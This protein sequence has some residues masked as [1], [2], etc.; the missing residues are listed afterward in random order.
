[1]KPIALALVAALLLPA[2][3]PATPSAAPAG[4][5]AA[6]EF[7]K[8]DGSADGFTLEHPPTWTVKPK[9][10]DG[11]LVDYL[12]R[13][14]GTYDNKTVFLLSVNRVRQD[15]TELPDM[16]IGCEAGIAALNAGGYT[17]QN[18]EIITLG[19]VKACEVWGTNA[20]ASRKMHSYVTSNLFLIQ[21]VYS[22]GN[23]HEARI[24]AELARVIQSFK[25]VK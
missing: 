5:V 20:L 10:S 15:V 2:C 24:K 23:E 12:V 22:I 3:Q 6:S 4:A 1:M 7:K 21:A 11:N 17:P 25:A 18:Q 13:L 19:N 14:S 9:G 8:Y 16:N